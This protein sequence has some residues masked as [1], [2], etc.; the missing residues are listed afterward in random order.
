MIVSCVCNSTR[1]RLERRI[2]IVRHTNLQASE[3]LSEKAR[4]RRAAR[5]DRFAS[6]GLISFEQPRSQL[7]LHHSSSERQIYGQVRVA[8]VGNLSGGYGPDGESRHAER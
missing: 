4:R 1:G 8:R 5:Y 7:V 2:V 6:D 3:T